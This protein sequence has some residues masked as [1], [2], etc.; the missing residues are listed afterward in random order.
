[1]YVITFCEINES[2]CRMETLIIYWKIITG[3]MVHVFKWKL[4][5]MNKYLLYFVLA[6]Q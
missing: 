5:T 1:M 2:V 6:E 4:G 3:V